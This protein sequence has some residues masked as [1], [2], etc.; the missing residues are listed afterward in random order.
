MC[1]VRIVLGAVQIGSLCGQRLVL[2]HVERRAGG[3][4]ERSRSSSARSSTIPP[5]A[6][7][8]RYA[9][10]FIQ[11]SSRAPIEPRVS[12]VSGSSTTR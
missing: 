9:V 6:R 5:R 3:L 4:P 8:T 11:S 12:G 10:G 7:F 2:E 1:G